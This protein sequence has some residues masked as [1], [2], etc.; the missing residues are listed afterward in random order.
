MVEAPFALAER[1]KADAMVTRV[2][3]LALGIATAD[4]GPILFAD[5]REPRR[6]RR[7]CGLEGRP[8]RRDRG[9]RSRAM[10]GLGAARERIVAVLGPDDRAGLLRG[11]PRLHRALPGGGPG[12]RALPRCRARARTTPSSTCRASSWRAS[13]EAGIARARRP[14]AAAPTP[15][16]DRFYSYRRTTHRGEP[17]YGRLISRHRPGRREAS[18]APATLCRAGR[19]KK[20]GRR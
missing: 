14:R 11:R 16:P 13:R 10:E 9:A 12:L 17:D 19:R 1:P 5:P 4:C 8:R 15:T 18:P 7:P 2:P 3:G 6:R 20:R